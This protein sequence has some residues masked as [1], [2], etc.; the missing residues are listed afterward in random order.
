MGMPEDD[1]LPPVGLLLAPTSD[2]GRRT[3][4]RVLDAAVQVFGA[5]TDRRRPSVAAVAEL[6]DV[7]PAAIYQYFPDRQALVL[8]AMERDCAV[9]VRD[10]LALA[11]RRTP[12]VITGEFLA[13]SRRLAPEHPLAVRAAF[14][15]HRD[16]LALPL[17]RRQFD[18]VAGVLTGE[19]TAAQGA[20]LVR[21]DL[22]AA[23]LADLLVTGAGSS[24]WGEAIGGD[25]PTARYR[26]VEAV[27]RAAV[28]YPLAG[29]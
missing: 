24:L 9:L 27:F 3:L 29:G 17:V 18:R 26:A 19:L 10:A 7:S 8:A 21:T 28:V 20:G 11:T 16:V 4:D 5:A 22:P 1:L 12:A 15:E 13:A 23:D 2:R 14:R 25:V 6:V